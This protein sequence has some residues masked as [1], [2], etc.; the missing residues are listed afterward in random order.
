MTLGRISEIYR[1]IILALRWTSGSEVCEPALSELEF[2]QVT[3]NHAE[4]SSKLRQLGLTQA[5][6][7]IDANARYVSL[8]WLALGK[9]H[10]A[11]A[12]AQVESAGRGAYSKAYYAVYNTSKAV[13]YLVKGTVSLKGDDHGLASE[14][15]D[16]FPE[17]DRW[18]QTI[19][20]LY[21]HRL[22]ADYDNW[23]ETASENSLTPEGAV[24]VAEEFLQVA[25]DYMIARLEDS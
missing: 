9:E 23:R 6:D 20:N 4:F 22:R 17:V 10:V 13:R 16:D 15:P 25:N 14:L 19:T 8:R 21:E 24:V 11:E 18:A 12:R 1:R 5:A 3:R 7:R 2:L